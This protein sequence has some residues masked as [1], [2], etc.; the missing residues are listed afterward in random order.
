MAPNS[1]FLRSIISNP[2]KISPKFLPKPSQN[3]ITRPFSSFE[4]NP[5]NSLD[6]KSKL[7]PFTQ[8]PISPKAVG[9]TQLI[10]NLFKAKTEGLFGNAGKVLDRMS[11]RVRHFTNRKSHEAME[12]SRVPDVM[13]HIAIIETYAN[14]GQ[15][16]EK[17]QKLYLKMMGAGVVPNEYTYNVLIKLVASTSGG[18]W[19]M[20]GQAQ[21]YMIEMLDKGMR[22]DVAT[23]V[24]VFKALA[25]EGRVRE[26]RELLE[27]VK[28][29]GF[30]VDD[31]VFREILKGRGGVVKV[32]KGKTGD[33]V[34]TLLEIFFAKKI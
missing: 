22:P 28:G 12:R 11:K 17:A 13:A 27:D 8:T 29:R 7:D 14:A 15:C 1:S 21:K 26:G 9:Q 32:L 24:A 31:R 16:S 2:N 20:I 25:K 34:R 6:P 3:L 10:E 33:V 5:P 30:V 23:C 4:S 18:D 19:M